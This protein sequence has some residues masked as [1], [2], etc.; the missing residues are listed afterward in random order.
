MAFLLLHN[1]TDFI[2][3]A[4]DFRIVRFRHGTDTNCKMVREKRNPQSYFLLV[5]KGYE[6][7]QQA[8]AGGKPV[9]VD[10]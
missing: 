5:V 8:E 3:C 2:R 9:Q 6:S 1:Y 7:R 4:A 10:E